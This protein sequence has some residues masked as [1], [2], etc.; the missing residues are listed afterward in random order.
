MAIGLVTTALA[1]PAATSPTAWRIEAS[2]ASA[3]LSSGWPGCAVAAWP[4]ETTG[5]A[6]RER[7]RRVLGANVGKLDVEPE[8]LGPVR[9]EVAI[10]E[11]I[12]CR[13]LQLIPAQ[14]R[15]DGDIGPDARG[16]A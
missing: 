3:L 16:F 7:S 13:E 1:R 5:S 12:E 4:V 8:R 10:A 2:A 9:E 6:S 15:L 14:P 11:Q